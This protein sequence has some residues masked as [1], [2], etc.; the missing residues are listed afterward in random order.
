MSGKNSIISSKIKGE[1]IIL[2]LNYLLLYFNKLM[3]YYKADSI[4]FWWYFSEIMQNLMLYMLLNIV[5]SVDY[6]WP[7]SIPSGF[8]T[9]W[10]D[11]RILHP[12]MAQLNCT[13]EMWLF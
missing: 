12:L 5:I 6:S 7:I 3:K 9:A 4:L 8:H 10:N 1:K 13:Q 11:E 2:E